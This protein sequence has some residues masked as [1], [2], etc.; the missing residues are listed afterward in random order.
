MLFVSEWRIYVDAEREQSAG[1]ETSTYRS[2]SRSL[3]SIDA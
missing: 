1:R 2:Q 3:I